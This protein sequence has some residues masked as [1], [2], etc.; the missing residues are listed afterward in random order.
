M[1]LNEL[2]YWRLHD[3][4]SLAQAAILIIGLTPSALGPDHERAPYI[5]IDN[6]FE[7]AGQEPKPDEQHIEITGKLNAVVSALI[8]AVKGKHLKAKE[9]YRNKRTYEQFDGDD[10]AEQWIPSDEID[11]HGTVVE[12][13]DLIKWLDTKN[14]R[15]NFFLPTTTS[16]P[17]YLNPINTRYAPK[18][19]AAVRAWQA[20]TDPNGKTPKQALVK[21][22]RENAALF[23]LTDEEGKINEDGIEQ[24]AKV[25]NWHPGGGAAK[26]PGE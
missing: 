2:D 23:G 22:L 5:K 9:V 16:T 8:M 7:G 14:I 19:A 25:A 13:V 10:F 20:V 4:M 6:P 17:D 11:P 1:E 26:T 18:L 15:P 3:S 24:V 21:W 12:V